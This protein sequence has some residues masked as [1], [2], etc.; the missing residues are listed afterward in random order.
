MGWASITL[1]FRHSKFIPYIVFRQNGPLQML[2]FSMR[3]FHHFVCETR[4]RLHCFWWWGVFSNCTKAMWWCFIFKQLFTKCFLSPL[5]VTSRLS[6]VLTPSQRGAPANPV[7][8]SKPTPIIL[9]WEA[10]RVQAVPPAIQ[11]L[12]GHD[13]APAHPQRRLALP[14]HHLPGVLPQPVSH[15]EAHERPQAGRHPSRLAHREDLP[16]PLLRLRP[17]SERREGGSFRVREGKGFG[18]KEERN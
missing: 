14:M 12:L 13:Q 15:A 1:L 4:H 9:R 7:F 17:E 3:L 16:V 18:V 6:K 11:G 2:W 5:R 10:I 8:F